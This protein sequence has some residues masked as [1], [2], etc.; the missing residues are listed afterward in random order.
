MKV[1]CLKCTHKFILLGSLGRHW[2]HIW[3]VTRCTVSSVFR[4]VSYYVS[5]TEQS[6]NSTACMKWRLSQANTYYAARPLLPHWNRRVAEMFTYICFTIKKRSYIMNS[7]VCQKNICWTFVAIALNFLYR[8]K[9]S[10]Q[11]SLC[12]KAIFNMFER[13]FFM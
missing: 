8:F 11:M 6:I 4:R 13:Q 2:Q 10:V 7:S 12:N 1:S 3:L 9:T 5:V